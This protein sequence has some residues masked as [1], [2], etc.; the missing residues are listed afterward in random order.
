MSHSDPEEFIGS[1]SGTP[2]LDVRS[3][4]EFEAGHIPGAI[5]FPLFTDEERRE[6]GTC[7]KEE[8]QEA[9]VL[10]GLKRVG[11]KLGSMVEKAR[12]ILQGKEVKLYCWR[13]GMRSNSVAWLLE[14]AGFSTQ[15]LSG[16]YKAYRRY[17]LQHIYFPS[18]AI[19]LGGY[20]GSRKT[21][22]LHELRAKGEQII[23]LE[24][25][26]GHR[27]SAFGLPEGCAQPT[28]EQFENNLYKTL[29]HLDPKRVVWVEDESKKIGTVFIRPQFYNGLEEAPLVVIEKS[30]EERAAYL[31]STYGN[32]SK[33][34]LRSGFER[35]AKRLGGQHVKR[36]KE[37][38]EEGNFK[39][40][41][42][43]ALVYYDK[44][45]AHGLN[46]RKSKSVT[47]YPATGLPNNEITTELIQIG[48][49][50]YG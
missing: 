26:A 50:I 36:A 47:Y 45:Y 18:K 24:A 14:M 16:G 9:A 49:R 13:G 20:T 11:P 3:P 34:R 15:V 27:G 2:V 22:L 41:A 28:M 1:H 32:E 29:C 6:I 19:V 44:T 25:M 37:C 5:S 33:E 7:Y 17:V 46:N 31:A 43:M 10:L 42:A 8:G 23:D 12:E 39:E 35:I 21:E 48:K 4:S 30:Q 38:L 40:A